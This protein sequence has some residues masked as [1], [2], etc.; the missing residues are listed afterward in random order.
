MWFRKVLRWIPKFLFKEV[1]HVPCQFFVSRVENR[2]G[3]K[4]CVATKDTYRQLHPLVSVVCGAVAENR[5][6]WQS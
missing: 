3:R 1:D 2:A 4:L 5:L 6:H